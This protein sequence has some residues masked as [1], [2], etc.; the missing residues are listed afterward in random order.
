MF[1]QIVDFCSLVIKFQTIQCVIKMPECK[2]MNSL[3]C[4][5]CSCLKIERH[6]AHLNK[7]TAE[8]SRVIAIDLY[9]T[10]ST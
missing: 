3:R 4:V 6:A 1:K 10:W 2:A 9:L 5:R 8:A 7:I